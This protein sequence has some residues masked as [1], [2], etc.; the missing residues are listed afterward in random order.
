[1]KILRN[2]N[3]ANTETKVVYKNVAKIDVVC[4]KN[5]DPAFISNK[6]SDAAFKTCYHL[7]HMFPVLGSR[8][9]CICGTPTDC[10]GDHA[11]VCPQITVRNQTRNTAHSNVSRGLRNALQPRSIHSGYYIVQGEPHLEDYVPR[12]HPV[13]PQAANPPNQRADIALISTSFPNPGAVTL[14]K[15]TLAAHNLDNMVD[16]SIL[17]GLLPFFVHGRSTICTTVP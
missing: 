8:K 1:M 2:I 4:K 9:F 12:L 13:D 6:M 17:L 3:G 5:V 16:L 11:L 10:F 15:V 7:R 14:I